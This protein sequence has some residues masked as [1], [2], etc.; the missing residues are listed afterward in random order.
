MRILY[1][2]MLETQ[3]YTKYIGDLFFWCYN[4]HTSFIFIFCATTKKIHAATAA[5]CIAVA[6]MP[7]IAAAATATQPRPQ[8]RTPYQIINISIVEDNKY[9]W[10]L[11]VLLYMLNFYPIYDPWPCFIFNHS[12]Y[13]CTE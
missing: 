7:T 8:F 13:S 10:S 12:T 1:L 6:A 3:I 9:L 11:L 5:I 4:C 2:N